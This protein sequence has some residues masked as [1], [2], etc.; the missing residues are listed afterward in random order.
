[1]CFYFNESFNGLI[2][3]LPTLGS[4]VCHVEFN[5]SMT[6]MRLLIQRHSFTA[7]NS[8]LKQRLAVTARGEVEYVVTFLLNIFHLF[9]DFLF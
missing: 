3:W 8:E 1:M 6:E 2:N 4:Y 9:N 5:A 7:L